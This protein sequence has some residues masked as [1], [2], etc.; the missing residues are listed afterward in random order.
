VGRDAASAPTQGLQHLRQL[1]DNDPN[2]G[3]GWHRLGNLHAKFGQIEQA[4]DAR[5]KA[6]EIDEREAEAAYCLARRCR[7]TGRCRTR[8]TTAERPSRDC[9]HATRRRSSG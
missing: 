3:E 4:E 1:T 7:D 2:N 8:R 5:R 9:Q 6:V